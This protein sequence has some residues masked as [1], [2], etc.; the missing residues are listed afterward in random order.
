MHAML[1]L[2]AFDITL[3]PALGSNLKCS[4][5]SHRVQS[6]N[7][8]TQAL[9]KGIHTAEEGNAMLATCYV[10]VFQSVLMEDG[11]PE[12]MSFIRGCAL[13][14]TTMGRK[15]MKFWFQNILEQDQ[16][17]KMEPHLEGV[18]EVDPALIDAA[19]SSL[20]AF[21]PLCRQNYEKI[22]HERILTTARAVYT[23]SREGWNP[24]PNV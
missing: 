14:A 6:I 8:L 3:T 11:I 17:S 12:F 5:I 4:A 13:V 18:P 16:I 19:C 15:G 7:A 10:L 21:A 1:G 22:F 9:S 20:E 23:S 24:S 2:S